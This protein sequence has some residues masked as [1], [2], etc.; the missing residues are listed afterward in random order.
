MKL[1]FDSQFLTSILFIGFVALL[2]RLYTSLVHKP[3]VLRSKLSKQGISGPPPTILL[4][5]LLDV[6]KARPR[7]T[8]T[9]T[10]NSPSIVTHN[11]ASL[12]FPKF[13]EWREQYGKLF[14]FS[15]GTIQVL[16][17]NETDIVKELT[18]CTS[19]DLGMP[20]TRKKLLKPLLGD[21]ILTASGTTWA[22][23]RKIL[24]PELYMEK[25]KE[26]VNIVSESCE[27]MLNLWSSK[28]E[29]EGGVADIDIDANMRRFSGNVISRACFGSDY[30]KGEE[31]FLK[32]GALEEVVFSWKNRASAIPGMRYI[33]TKTNIKAWKLE[34]EVKSLIL[35]VVK[36]RKEKTSYEKDMLQMLIE[37][38][39][40]SNLTQDACENIVIDNC[41]NIYLAAFETTA[42]AA[43]WCLMLLASNQ[44]WQDRV[45]AE[46]LQICEGRI[47][48]FNMLSNMK[49]LTMVVQ[50]SLR[51]YPPVPLVSRH[52]FNDRKFGNI[53]V[54]NGTNIWI[55]I[56][57]LH[58]NPDIWGD[59]AY[60]FN[61]E[62]FANGVVGACKHPHVYMPFGVGPR[63]CLGQNLAILELKMLMA[64]ILSKFSFS[65]SPRY[66]HSPVQGLLMK[67][68]HGVQL[69][70]KKL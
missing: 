30:S 10:P 61:P 8:P 12:V 52:V 41:K 64:L 69:L 15:L 65:L 22:N 5:N 49:Q 24:A 16:C 27:S 21:G 2:F 31:I 55:M 39:E 63:V 66:V 54:P 60:E 25:V 1:Q 57:S 53:D 28:I 43:T 36:K 19:F 20:S 6:M 42:V 33:P 32:L 47:P 13:E 46:V 34:K 17:V 59:D 67:P 18:T 48:D 37:G 4:G 68:D 56:I 14:M 23:H 35:E 9:T 58:T 7:S 40:K 62:R 26:M 3:N 38:I 70:V 51:L 50:E 44:N 11:T 29:A 45:R